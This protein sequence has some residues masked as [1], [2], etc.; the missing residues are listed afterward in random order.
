MNADF[1]QFIPLFS[2]MAMPL[3]A[4][5]IY[6]ALA[7]YVRQIGPMRTLITGE[8]TY[9]GAY[10]GFLFF[11]IYL[12]S[13]PFQ[14]LFPHPWP[15]I[16]SGLREFCMI[17][18]FGP[19][20]FLAMLSLVFGA[21]NIPRRVIQAVVGLGVLLGLVFIVVNIFAI[22]GSEPIFQ[23]GRLTAHDGLWFKNPDASRRSF[24]WILFAVRFVDP[25][26]LVFLAGTVV[27]WHARNYP[28]EKRMLYDNMPIKLYLLGASCYSFA[29]SML[30]TGLLYV[31]NGLPNQWWVYYAGALLAGFLETASLAL[32]MKKHVQVS[33]HL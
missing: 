6:F 16:L 7:K 21:E 19:A 22:G 3:L 23:V 5:L 11:G 24:M 17:A 14:L 30:T 20:V 32:P 27:L 29:L 18:V 25:V 9:K 13:R 33:E 28:V 26:L 10:L 31:V 8:L 12:A 4:G 1:R 15:L 2:N